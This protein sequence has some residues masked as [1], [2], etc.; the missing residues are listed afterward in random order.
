ML[1]LHSDGRLLPAEWTE[2]DIY[3]LSRL[4]A[5]MI[6]VRD[7]RLPDEEVLKAAPLIDQWAI[8]T[9]PT[10]VLTGKVYGHPRYPQLGN[11][12]LTT[13]LFIDGRTHGWMRTQ[14]RYYRLGE[15]S[16]E[17]ASYRHEIF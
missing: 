2:Q 13:P 10:A 11:P 12:I 5:D 9:R 14:S 16:T 3:R 7:G 6:A 4:T 8:V 17:L 15:A 1:S